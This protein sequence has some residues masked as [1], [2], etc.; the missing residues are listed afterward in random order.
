MA[1]TTE[2][3]TA[4]TAATPDTRVADLEKLLAAETNRANVA[5][6]NYAVLAADSLGKI[7]ALTKKLKDNKS[8]PTGDVVF[9]EGKSYPVVTTVRADNTF[10]EVKRG[11][12]EEGATMVVIS[13]VH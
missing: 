1:D 2:N 13:R 9:L 7:N 5:E 6:K 8:A 3:T 4:Q 11:H 10:H 12:V